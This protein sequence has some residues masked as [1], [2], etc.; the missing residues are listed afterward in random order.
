[1]IVVG[2][3][4]LSPNCLPYASDIFYHK[5]LTY[6]LP[7]GFH[8]V[9][10]KAVIEFPRYCFDH[11]IAF[12][13]ILWEMCSLY[14]DNSK[15]AQEALDIIEPLRGSFIQIIATIY[16]R[17]RAAIKS[18]KQLFMAHPSLQ[19]C[20]R[21]TDFDMRFA[22][23]EL[24]S[25]VLFEIFMEGGYEGAVNYLRVNSKN[26]EEFF[27]L[28]EAMLINR[29]RMLPADTLLLQEQTWYPLINQ[30]NSL[31][32]FD[33]PWDSVVHEVDSFDIEHFRY[34]LFETILSPIFGRCDSQQRGSR[35]GRMS[36]GHGR[37]CNREDSGSAK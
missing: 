27:Q 26:P 10:L 19:E 20:F 8:P 15:A 2:P 32:L 17:D 16:P 22:A 3:G 4:Y 24:L 37:R 33:K 12:P 11:S 36:D 30:M 14:F 29:L 18:A 1:V 6:L 13:E 28:V 5:K 25:H 7:T 31:G 34:K 21:K 35:R 23:R 9:E